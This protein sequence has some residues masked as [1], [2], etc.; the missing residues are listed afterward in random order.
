MSC[1][2]FCSATRARVHR[3][4][5]FIE[6]LCASIFQQIPYLFEYL[7]VG[8]V[9]FQRPIHV[10]LLGTSSLTGPRDEEEEEK[11]RTI[12]VM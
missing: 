6:S 10:S 4:F 2:N 8:Q 5:G 12:Q 3:R 1:P 11:T 9:D 7:L